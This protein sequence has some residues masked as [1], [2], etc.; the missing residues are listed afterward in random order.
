MAGIGQY[1]WPRIE[2]MKNKKGDAETEVMSVNK[3]VKKK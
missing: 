1:R 2:S 3:L